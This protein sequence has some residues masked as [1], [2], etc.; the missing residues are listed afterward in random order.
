MGGRELKEGIQPLREG[1]PCRGEVQEEFRQ[2]NGTTVIGQI[3]ES[4]SHWQFRS[5]GEGA[6]N[7]ED[8]S[9]DSSLVVVHL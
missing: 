1:V 5:E 3:A 6:T 2:A 9:L 8:S 4:P 7:Y